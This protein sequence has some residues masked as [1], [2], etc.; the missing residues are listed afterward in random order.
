MIDDVLPAGGALLPQAAEGSFDHLV[1]EHQARL[2]VEKHQALNCGAMN[3]TDGPTD[4]QRIKRAIG[5]SGK[6]GVTVDFAEA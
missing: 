2:V 6:P 4:R 5:L 1:G 3:R